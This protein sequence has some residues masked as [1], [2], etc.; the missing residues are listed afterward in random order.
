VWS[1]GCEGCGGG[2]GDGGSA[3]SSPN[4]DELDAFHDVLLDWMEVLV[5]ADHLVEIDGGHRWSG[6]TTWSKSTVVIGG[7]G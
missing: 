1:S 7:Q 6:L 4:A 2:E 5:R 3:V